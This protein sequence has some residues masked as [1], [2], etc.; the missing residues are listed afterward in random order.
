MVHPP[1]HFP[2]FAEVTHFNMSV[3]YRTKLSTDFDM[4]PKDTRPVSCSVNTP[5]LFPEDI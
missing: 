2:I 1:V 3:K 4:L 5:T